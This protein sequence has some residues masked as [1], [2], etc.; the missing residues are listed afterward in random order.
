M[1]CYQD[2]RS[3]PKG[4]AYCF[5]SREKCPSLNAR[6]MTFS[7]PSILRLAEQHTHL[8]LLCQQKKH[9]LSHVITAY[10]YTRRPAVFLTNPTFSLPQRSR[11]SA[12]TR[13]T[14]MTAACPCPA[15]SRE[16]SPSTCA[17]GAWSGPAACPGTRSIMSTRTSVRL[18][19]TLVSARSEV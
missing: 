4:S 16:R 12:G 14:S 3:A 5:C 9:L 1:L 6:N 19:M 13:A 7:C 8:S 15:C 17:P 18:E 10:I 2:L 11:R